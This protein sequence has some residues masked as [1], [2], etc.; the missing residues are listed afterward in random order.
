MKINT[1]LNYSRE[2]LV[3]ILENIYNELY[4]TDKDLNVLY[5]SKTCKENYGLLQE[6]MI[7]KNHLNFVGKNWFPSVLSFVPIEKRRL[8][9][10]QVT[11]TGKKLTAT[12][13]PVFDE[14]N[15][16]KFTIS[17]VQ[18]EFKNLDMTLN[19]EP[20]E[21]NPLII[22]ENECKVITRSDCMKKILIL[23]KKIALSDIPVLIQGES[24]TGKSMLA[25]YIHEHSPRKGHPFLSINCS[26]I[27]ENLL[28]S[29]LFG[30]APY[31]FTDANPKGKKG[32]LSLADN[33][34]LFLDEIGE[35]ALSL[36]AKLLNVVENC[37]F[38]PIG[39]KK[40]ETVNVR[41]IS[42]TNK[43]LEK[44]ILE[45]TF[46]ED[47]YWRLNIIDL[48]MPSL[49]ER[50]ED[51]LP[52]SNYYL[53][54]HNEKYKSQ[55]FFSKEVLVL[56]TKYPWPGNIRQLKNL[57]ERVF[58]VSQ[59]SKISIS[60]LPKILVKDKYSQSSHIKETNI[61]NLKLDNY[62][63]LYIKKMY[64]IHNSSRKM[65]K[66]LNISQ[67]KANILINKYCL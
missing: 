15:N 19:S 47:L 48:K 8:C 45:K 6:E 2:T 17:I 59:N 37:Q 63:E 50:S 46:R 18:E 21:D 55:K 33:G 56:F 16:L 38:I 36:Q 23:S 39:S 41:I 25:K 42:A 22:R 43:N 60:D 52:L 31:A 13:S 57:I 62:E 4:I 29:E 30:Y 1:Y 28:E 26:A 49:L 34:T 11:T 7:G 14:N 67:S 27:P 40:A 51:I 12:A 24:G 58:I 54:T 10:S 61:L 53:N 9:I 3:K 20:L 64:I 44:L 35:L 65:A 32:L 66:T 5:V